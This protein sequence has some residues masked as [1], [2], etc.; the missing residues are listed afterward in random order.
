EIHHAFLEF[1]GAQQRIDE[2]AE[3]RAG[4]R[5]RERKVERHGITSKAFADIGV[6]NGRDEQTKAK[7]KHEEIEHRSLQKGRIRMLVRLAS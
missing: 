6:A 2:V 4:Y 3:Q 5:R 7:T 1:L